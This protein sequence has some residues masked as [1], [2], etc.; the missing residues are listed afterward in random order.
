M[1]TF[2]FA[3]DIIGRIKIADLRDRLEQTLLQ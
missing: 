2:A 1:L 3:N